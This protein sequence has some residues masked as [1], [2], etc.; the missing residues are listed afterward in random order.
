MVDEEVARIAQFAGANRTRLPGLGSGS[1]GLTNF[2]ASYQAPCERRNDLQVSR[3]DGT[4][5]HAK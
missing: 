4:S 2:A 5:G 3:R 1:V